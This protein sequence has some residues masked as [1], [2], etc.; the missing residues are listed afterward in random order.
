MNI[1]QGFDRL[2]AI[3]ACHCKIKEQY[4]IFLCLQY[5][6]NVGHEK[7]SFVFCKCSS[8]FRNVFILNLVLS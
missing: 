2:K 7:Y 6:V 1:K 8:F 3:H 4:Q 5:N